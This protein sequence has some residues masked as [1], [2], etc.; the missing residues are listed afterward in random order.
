MPERFNEGKAW[1]WA[2]AGRA[3]YSGEWAGGRQGP[4]RG[5]PPTRS[6]PTSTLIDPATTFGGFGGSLMYSSPFWGLTL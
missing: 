5:L 4:I 1:V 6:P 3:A 2:G